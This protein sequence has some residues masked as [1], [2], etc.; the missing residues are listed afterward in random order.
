MVLLEAHG[1]RVRLDPKHGGQV[2]ELSYLDKPVFRT[3]QPSADPMQSSCF[4]LAPYANRIRDARFCYRGDHYKLTQN[5]E[6]DVHAIHGE[7][8]LSEWSVRMKSSAACQ[9]S[10]VGGE[11][12][13]WAYTANQSVR[14]GDGGVCFELELSSDSQECFPIGAGF[15]PYF[16]RFVDT[17][18]Q[19]HADGVLESRDL[20]TEVFQTLNADLSFERSRDLRALNVDCCF[21]GWRN[22]ARILQPQMGLEIKISSSGPSEWCNVYIPAGEDFFCF[23]PVSHA[24]GAFNRASVDANGLCLLR[25]GGS[26]RFDMMISAEARQTC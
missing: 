8:W 26:F 20:R 16:P 13:P 4:P 17:E 15:H 10:Y 23:E 18:L 12:W 22:T 14:I 3:T 11:N 24:T 7:G 1:Y 5:W 19:F 6:G 9:M 25:P 21:S 2:Q